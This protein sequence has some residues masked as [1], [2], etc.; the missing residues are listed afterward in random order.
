MVLCIE[1]GFK[2]LSI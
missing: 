1:L 2:F